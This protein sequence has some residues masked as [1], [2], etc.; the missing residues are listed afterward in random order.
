MQVYRFNN[1]KNWI[2]PFGVD[3]LFMDGRE[4]LNMSASINGVAIQGVGYIVNTQTIGSFFIGLN[5]NISSIPHTGAQLYVGFDL[6]ANIVSKD[7]LT[8]TIVDTA[9]VSHL[10]EDGYGK[11]VALRM[12]GNLKIGIHGNFV[13]NFVIHPYFTIGILNLLGRNDSRGE[14][15]TP[16]RISFANDALHENESF[17]STIGFCFLIQYKL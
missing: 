7:H 8:Q 15:L 13:N 1:D 14:L 3:V 2:V 4:R 9:N 6:R 5:R 12:G 10:F 17:V 11:S 16:Q